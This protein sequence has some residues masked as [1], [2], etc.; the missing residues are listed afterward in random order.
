MDAALAKI[1]AR[2]HQQ[3]GLVTWAQMQDEGVKDHE[4]KLLVAR[5]VLVRVR[6]QVYAIAGAPATWEQG[7]LAASLSAGS[8]AAVSHASAAWLWRYAHL[9]E[10]RYEIMVPGEL[11]PRLKGVL[12]HRTTLWRD[13]DVV[14][15]DGIR[16]T[17]FERT[18]CDCT[19]LLSEFQLGRV[20][21]EGLRRGVASLRRLM[22]CAEHLESARGRHMTV[23]RALLASRDATYHPGGSHSELRVL[24]VL[25]GAGFPRPEQQHPIRVGKQTYHPDYAWPRWKILIEYYGLPYHIGASSVVHDNDRLTELTTDGWLPLVFTDAASDR[26]IIEKTEAAFRRRGVPD[27]RA[28]RVA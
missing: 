21:D 5:H 24:D 18:L 17:S 14:M 12:L 19:T 15:L 27:V 10:K 20:L 4:R 25:V 22:D 13:T 16:C 11:R 6:P 8:D 9:P 2:A 1:A 28:L 26:R 3:R 7:L 23:V